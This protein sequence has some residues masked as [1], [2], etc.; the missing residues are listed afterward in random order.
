[1]SLFSVFGLIDENKCAHRESASI[2]NAICKRTTQS[3]LLWGILGFECQGKVI[4][5]PFMEKAWGKQGIFIK[6]K[7]LPNPIGAGSPPCTS[8][9]EIMRIVWYYTHPLNWPPTCFTGTFGRICNKRS[10][11][12]QTKSAYLQPSSCN[13]LYIKPV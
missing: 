13:L 1:M 11:Y 5:F 9:V 12:F 8:L 6:N 4:Y 10:H 3:K 2:L 7:Q